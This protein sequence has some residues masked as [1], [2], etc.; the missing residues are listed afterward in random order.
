[1]PLI[2]SVANCFLYS[3]MLVGWLWV[4]KRLMAREDKED[5]QSM[6]VFKQRLLRIELSTA[7]AFA[8]LEVSNGVGI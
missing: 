1:M 4:K 7:I 6:M 3:L 5:A 2:F 8:V